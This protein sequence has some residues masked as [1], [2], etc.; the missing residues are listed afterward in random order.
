MPMEMNNPPP[1]THAPATFRHT[2]P[3]TAV[4]LGPQ[5]SKTY[6]QGLTWKLFPSVGRQPALGSP[7]ARS[8]VPIS[9]KKRR[10]YSFFPDWSATSSFLHAL[11]RPT[12]NDVATRGSQVQGSV[13][14]RAIRTDREPRSVRQ[15]AH[16]ER[17]EGRE[18][19]RR[20][21]RVAENPHNQATHRVLHSARTPQLN[22]L[23]FVFGTLLH[24]PEF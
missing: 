10:N 20:L 7:G 6:A 13:T 1:T 22:L 8:R 9:H 3:H 11:L 18:D 12:G 16:A 4:K 21:R 23:W 2:Q 5:A 19:P 14:V 24:L 17:V 15:G